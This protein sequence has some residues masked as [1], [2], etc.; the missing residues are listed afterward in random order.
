MDR[1]DINRIKDKY[2]VG[3]V[4]EVPGYTLTDTGHT[5]TMK[6]KKA[7]IIGIYSDYVRV[8][9]N[10][11]SWCVNWCDLLILDQKYGN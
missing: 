2:R 7:K 5:G 8:T 9:S 10:N 11:Y 1:R 3:D 6:R 4:I